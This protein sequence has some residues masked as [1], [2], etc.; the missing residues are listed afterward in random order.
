MT[1]S[2]EAVLAFI[3]GE[4]PADEEMRVAAE[5]AGDPELAAYVER[6][7]ALKARLQSDFSAVLSEPVPAR[8]ES[9]IL[10]DAAR[11]QRL[12]TPLFSRRAGG[13]RG[14]LAGLRPF[15]WI[16]AIAAAAGF[17]IG[18]IMAPQIG[19]I[20]IGV[21][22]GT[23]VARGALARA[24]STQLAS[25]QDTAA[26]T[27]IGVTFRDDGGATCRSFISADGEDGFAGIACREGADWRI[28]ALT[29]V[30]APN[31]ALF[32]PAA[33]QLPPI[34]LQSLNA[35]MNGLP[36]DADEERAARDGG[37]PAR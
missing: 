4:L 16:P 35:M 25:E 1:V 11:A 5:I 15:A 9:M 3:D 10:D 12:R 22:D 37:W 26:A 7:K 19:G 2:R 18:L 13:R 33:A 31:P 32:Q 34:L 23:L 6:Q 14:G 17:A 27:R 21:A 29:P 28:A 36:F 20:P 8:F 24:L 30:E